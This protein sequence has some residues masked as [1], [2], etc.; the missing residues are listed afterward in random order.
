MEPES[1]KRVLVCC[2]AGSDLVAETAVEALFFIHYHPE[3]YAVLRRSLPCPPPG[4]T[5]V[6][7][8][9]KA[10]GDMLI[11]DWEASRN[12]GRDLARNADGFDS[13]GAL[14]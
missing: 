9:P 10:I 3:I 13:S 8:D 4:E 11:C 6:A 1:T 7:P 5:L 2:P 14:P 12:P